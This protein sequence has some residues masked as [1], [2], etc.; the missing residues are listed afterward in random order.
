MAPSYHIR[1]ASSLLEDGKRI[2]EFADSQAS[3][4]AQIGSGE[5]WGSDSLSASE[6]SQQKYRSLVERSE[7]QQTW[8][9]DW[10]QISM[11]EAE[12]DAFP[13]DVEHLTRAEPSRGGRQLLPVAAMVLEGR[14]SEYTRPVLPEQDDQDPFVYI[15]FL[16]TDRRV[17]AL[18]KGSGQKML[19]HAEDVARAL[20]VARLCLDAW[21]GNDYSLVKYVVN[22]NLM[23]NCLLMGTNP[24]RYYERQ[25]F[26]RLGDVV[27][28]PDWPATVLERRI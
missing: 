21:S 12:D 8:S 2:L 13:A 25:G 27:D 24:N 7:S 10:V 22:C 26:R 9:K 19:K 15:R 5:Q 3:H 28:E 14:S 16:V 6:T 1:P 17:G 4:L 23:S 11:L 20:E 18:S